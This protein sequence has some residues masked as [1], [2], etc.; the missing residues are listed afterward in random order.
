MKTKKKKYLKFYI[1]NNL[2]NK[3]NKVFFINYK[4]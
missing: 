3:L 1:N 2:K 4:L